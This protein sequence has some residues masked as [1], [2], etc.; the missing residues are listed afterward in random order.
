MASYRHDSFPP[1]SGN[2]PMLTFVKT[3]FFSFIINLNEVCKVRYILDV[4]LGIRICY[5]SLFCIIYLWLFQFFGLCGSIHRMRI[6]RNLL[7][8]KY[9]ICIMKIFGLTR[10]L[11]FISIPDILFLT[12]YTRFYYDTVPRRTSITFTYCNLWVL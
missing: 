7:F 11:V 1:I 6:Q 9:Y 8:W 4:I 5:I 2:P 12:P 3:I 10:I